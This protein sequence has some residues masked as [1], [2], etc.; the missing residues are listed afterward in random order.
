[1]GTAR[2]PDVQAVA[3]PHI[4]RHVR[5]VGTNAEPRHRR[6]LHDEQWC[7][8]QLPG[9]RIKLVAPQSLEMTLRPE[10]L[11]ESRHRRTS[12]RRRIERGGKMPVAL[13]AL[14]EL[15][16]GRKYVGEIAMDET[17]PLG[18]DVPRLELAKIGVVAA[19]NV[20]EE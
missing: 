10:F 5:P 15:R 4:A 6:A 20:V 7:A 3:L 12:L 19:C 8:G 13:A 1:G 17:R 16:L 11:Q 9:H 14:E 2:N 18:P